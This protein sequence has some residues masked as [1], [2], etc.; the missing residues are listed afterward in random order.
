[1]VTTIDA[2]AN[3][4]RREIL[5][6]VWNVELSSGEIA[7]HFDITWPSISRNLKVL[8]EAGLVRER[9]DGNLRFYR[10]DRKALRPLE[11]LLLGMWESDLDRL[12]RIVE[13]KSRKKARR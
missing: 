9:R 8:R 4:H 13:T 7:G 6:L 5:R 12:A 1:M 11:G 3:P 2:V 10:A